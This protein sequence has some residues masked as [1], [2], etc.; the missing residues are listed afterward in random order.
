M[1]CDGMRCDSDVRGWDGM[2]CIITLNPANWSYPAVPT[3]VVTKDM[4][5]KSRVR[6]QTLH[7][8]GSVLMLAPTL[9]L[10]VHVCMPLY[11]HVHAHISTSLNT[12]TYK[13]TCT[14]RHA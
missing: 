5:L 13:Q 11:I 10:C 7:P 9:Y 2:G 8:D 4:Y 6:I 12:D 1:G 3:L 14:M